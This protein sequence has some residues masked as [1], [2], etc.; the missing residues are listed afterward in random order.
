MNNDTIKAAEE[1]SND[2]STQNGFIAG[3]EYMQSQKD[4]QIK[5]LL[6]ALEQTTNE[7][8]AHLISFELERSN[9]Q[10]IKKHRKI[11]EENPLT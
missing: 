4:E 6:E 11:S 8:V 10:L 3:S 1:Y 2:I 5:E 7:T 9:K